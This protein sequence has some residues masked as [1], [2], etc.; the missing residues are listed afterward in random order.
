M[1]GYRINMKYI[2]K[3]KN[4]IALL[5]GNVPEGQ[6]VLRGFSLIELIVV[7]TIIA[8]ISVAG[9]VS[10][11]G[12]NK[13][14]RDARRVADLEKMRIALEMIRQ[15]GTTYPA[16]ASSLVSGNFMQ[17]LPTDPKSGNAYDYDQTSGGYGYSIGATLEDPANPNYR[18][19]NP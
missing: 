9:M 18:V 8:L 6:R 19:Y 5:K 11:S 2:I 13:K 3:I 10:Y 1:E 14:S 17:A 16:N 12:T 7:I 15:V 4:R